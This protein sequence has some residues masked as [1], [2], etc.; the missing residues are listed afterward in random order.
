[1]PLEQVLG[2][3]FKGIPDAYSG[4]NALAM[5]AASL[6][7]WAVRN[8]LVRAINCVTSHTQCG[9]LLDHKANQRS[10]LPCA[11][12]QELAR[13]KYLRLRRAEERKL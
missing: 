1:M 5:F 4:L 10:F 9:K 11:K 13:H 3:V 8:I 6:I 12:H 7:K 2:W